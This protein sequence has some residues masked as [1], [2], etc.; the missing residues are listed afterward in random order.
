MKR[1][2]VLVLTIF[3]AAL[4]A[5]CGKADDSQIP[6]P[7]IEKIPID[8]SS[9]EP[10]AQ[11]QPAEGQQSAEEQYLQE[12]LQK[13]Q[14]PE[15]SK[16]ETQ[17]H[18]G[19]EAEFSF[20]DVSDRLFSFSSGAGAWSTSL[21]INSDGSFEGLYNDSDMGDSGE[22][23]PGGTRYSCSFKGR[24]D[25]L[26]RVDEFTY[27]MRL[28][29][30]EFEQEPGR[31]EL[32]DDVRY[33]YSTAY[34]LDGGEEFYLYLPGAELAKLPEEYRRW[35]GYYNL[36]EISETKLPFYGLY[37][38]N[39]ENGFSSC[40]YERPGFSK[41][42]AEE[43]S[44]AEERY[45]ELEAKLQE[46]NTQLDMNVTS[47]EMFQVWDD[48]LNAV[49]KLLESELDGAGMETLRAEEKNW[50]SYKEEQVKAAGQ[51][52][53]GGSMQPLAESMKAVELTRE[54]VYELAKYAE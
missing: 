24:F 2:A 13:E 31:E 20:A 17:P 6:Y 48:T 37:N 14:Q 43:I 22:G 54:R 39:E 15:V 27:K 18:E 53:E 52:Y 44:Y 25:S 16:S 21:F 49:W 23:Y 36:E 8:E 10:S 7:V 5:G 3:I 30:L 11:G 50:I 46:A 12:E 29:S 34:G 47:G 41:R 42:I 9:E 19:T 4:S 51:E 35:V 40:K 26:E 33:I 38:I 28:A 32:A 1:K 45:A